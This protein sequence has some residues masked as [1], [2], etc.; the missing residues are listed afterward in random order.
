MILRSK[1]ED[2]RALLQVVALS[3]EKNLSPADIVRHGALGG[4]VHIFH[5]SANSAMRQFLPSVM[6][7]SFFSESV[8]DGTFAPSLSFT[9]ENDVPRY[10]PVSECLGKDLFTA[11]CLLFPDCFLE[12]E[13]YLDDQ[14]FDSE[15]IS[16]TQ[17][18]GV[19]D[20][21]T[22][23]AGNVGTPVSQ[24]SAD[25]S[26]SQ[27]LQHAST[28]HTGAH[29]ATPPPS[30]SS[31]QR[32][33][34]STEV[35][36]IVLH[37]TRCEVALDFVVLINSALKDVQIR[38]KRR[39]LKVSL[40]PKSEKQAEGSPPS[41]DT[42]EA[43]V[44][45][46]N[47]LWLLKAKS[48]ILV[49]LY[50]ADLFYLKNWTQASSV[51]HSYKDRFRDTTGPLEEFTEPVSQWSWPTSEEDVTA[52]YE[53]KIQQVCDAFRSDAPPGSPQ[54][55]EEYLRVLKQQSTEDSYD[56]LSSKFSLLLNKADTGKRP[57]YFDALQFCHVPLPLMPVAEGEFFWLPQPTYLM[58]HASVSLV[59]H[60]VRL[61]KRKLNDAQLRTECTVLFPQPFHSLGKMEKDRIEFYL[62]DRQN[63]TQQ[64]EK[65]PVL[66]AKLMVWIKES[67]TEGEVPPFVSAVEDYVLFEVPF[68]VMVGQYLRESVSQRSLSREKWGKWLLH[69]CQK[70]LNASA[71]D[72]G[73]SPHTKV[74]T[75]IID[76]SLAQCSWKLSDE[77]K[78]TFTSFRKLVN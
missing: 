74:I 77:E 40:Q 44:L 38:L 35:D 53:S 36:L 3:Q 34:R 55:F 69:T 41:N 31:S 45:Q 4:V 14:P 66:L 28:S 71:N 33:P 43:A 5:D 52:W 6:S 12:V 11:I 18:Q 9:T 62:Q 2:F 22:S 49:C 57:S 51:L 30:L 37:K 7:V 73:S 10:T 39:E 64:L 65:N 1:L 76:F 58:S 15:S 26:T 29:S 42:S 21:N 16:H 59:S 48:L 56:I 63:V 75:A 13:D 24:K 54:D 47:S 60:L 23:A 50:V 70:L 17:S 20:M 8:G 46:N 27:H 61:S 68:S 72:G 32:A 25:A 67:F 19:E 78:T